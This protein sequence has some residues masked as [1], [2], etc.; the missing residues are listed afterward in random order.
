MLWGGIKCGRAGSRE[1]VIK[2]SVSLKYNKSLPG[3]PARVNSPHENWCYYPRQTRS[4]PSVFFFSFLLPPRPSVCLLSRHPASRGPRYTGC[5]LS[6]RLK[7][8]LSPADLVS[9][10]GV[11]Q[12][13]KN[14][15]RTNKWRWRKNRPPVYE[16]QGKDQVRMSPKAVFGLRTSRHIKSM[17]CRP[18]LK[19][20]RAF[21]KC[22]Q[23]INMGIW[24]EFSIRFSLQI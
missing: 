4:S 17:Y 20:S 22:K 19:F 1:C 13:R 8:S 18:F 7:E 14:E 24:Q 5:L 15:C 11:E 3:W 6:L 2:C 9:L 16:F 12:R 10:R 23:V 21:R